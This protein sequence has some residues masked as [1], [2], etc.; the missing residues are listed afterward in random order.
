MSVRTR[1]LWWPLWGL[2]GIV[3]VH[4]GDWGHAES[5]ILPPLRDYESIDLPGDAGTALRLGGHVVLDPAGIGVGIGTGLS[6]IG[7]ALLVVFLAAL[8]RHTRQVEGPGGIIPT[9]ILAGG[10]V[11]IAGLL[12]GYAVIWTLLESV[13][14]GD[15]ASTVQTLFVLQG[16][17]AYLPWTW[18]GI[19]TG[20]LAV[21]SF[22]RR[23]VPLLLGVAS[24]VFT[25]LFI[26]AALWLP[27]ISPFLATIWILIAVAALLGR[28]EHTKG[29]GE[30]R[31]QPSP[32]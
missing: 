15:P 11:T 17:L 32:A 25:L 7:L 14:D 30:P 16:S 19:V 18:L 23:S 12:I 9:V 3:L 29:S 4:L 20:A 5:P 24:A 26:L 13:T 21:S 6:W 1:R 31:H 8:S 10:L 27:F 22:T 2:A 28:Q